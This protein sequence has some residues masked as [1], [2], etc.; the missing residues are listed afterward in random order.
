MLVGTLGILLRKLDEDFGL[1]KGRDEYEPV[2]VQA[3]QIC[4][5]SSLPFTTGETPG[6]W[7]H[8]FF[9]V[10]FPLVFGIEDYAKVVRSE[11]VERNLK[12]PKGTSC[13]H[14]SSTL[15]NIALHRENI[16]KHLEL[17]TVREDR[18]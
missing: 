12:G 15:M 10:S 2:W 7:E 1:I 18:T 13:T 6:I 3:L 14:D 17:Q 8:H 4:E 9:L 11:L 5:R 16:R